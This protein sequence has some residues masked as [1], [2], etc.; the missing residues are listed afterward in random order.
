MGDHPE[1]QRL[2]GVQRRAAGDCA[3]AGRLKHDAAGLGGDSH[4][5]ED[6]CLL[7]MQQLVNIQRPLEG[8]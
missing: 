8:E 1:A 5:R 2:L 7:E 4:C 3:A 6:E